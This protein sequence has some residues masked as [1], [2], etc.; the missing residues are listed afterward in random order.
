MFALNKPSKSTLAMTLMEIIITM[1]IISIVMVSIG[2]LL[3]SGYKSYDRVHRKLNLQQQGLYALNTLSDDL[4]TTRKDGVRFNSDNRSL[5]IAS[6]VLQGQTRFSSSGQP[7]WSNWIC[8]FID[9]R[10]R[11]MR[12]TRPI[13]PDDRSS[14]LPSLN[15]FGNN[16][17]T[18]FPAP[19]QEPTVATLD[20]QD[21]FVNE[22]ENIIH[23]EITIGDD[24]TEDPSGF[25]I[26][27][28]T[29]IAPVYD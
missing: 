23:I 10:D 7:V 8:Y 22:E 17:V 9:D 3:I 11:L 25:Q 27:L 24:L 6:P 15:T 20:V 14:T 13:A 21:I 29:G 19:G 1:G 12:A 26:S 5:L 28:E 4:L 2:T 16:F 18:S